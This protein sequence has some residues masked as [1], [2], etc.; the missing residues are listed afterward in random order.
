MTKNPWLGIWLSAANSWAGA[1]CGFWAAKMHREQKAMLREIE[2]LA[3]RSASMTRSA[4]KASTGS[5]RKP[6]G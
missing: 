6:K 3:A 5:R 4:K 1:A 2:K